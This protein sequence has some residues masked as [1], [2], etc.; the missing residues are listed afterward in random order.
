M[1]K[2]KGRRNDILAFLVIFWEEGEILLSIYLSVY[3]SR[4]EEVRCC[5]IVVRLPD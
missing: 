1:K 4:L 2:W 5:G 3:Y